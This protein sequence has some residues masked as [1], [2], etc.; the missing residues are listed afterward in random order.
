VDLV[1]ALTLLKPGG[2]IIVDDY[3]N[4]MA[5]NNPLLRPRDAVDFVVRS[6]DNEIEFSLTAERQA[7][8]I[9]K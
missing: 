9:R 5:T 3:L 4:N 7:V 2:V 8:I 1:H 6:F